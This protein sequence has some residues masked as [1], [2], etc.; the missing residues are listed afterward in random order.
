MY[1]YIYNIWRKY[2]HIFTIFG[3]YLY[4]K[5]SIVN[6]NSK[7][8]EDDFTDSN[9]VAFSQDV[10]SISSMKLPHVKPRSSVSRLTPL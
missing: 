1:A 9:A 7:Y 5:A 10:L 8:K 3:G 4:N 2:M 6:T